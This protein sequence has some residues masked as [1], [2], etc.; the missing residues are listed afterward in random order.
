MTHH[1]GYYTL[2]EARAFLEDHGICIP[3]EKIRAGLIQGRISWGMAIM[4]EKQYSFFVFPKALDEWVKANFYS[5]D[6]LDKI[7]GEV[8]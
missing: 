1:N 8:I 2:E 3:T 6:E 7:N 5:W 4:G